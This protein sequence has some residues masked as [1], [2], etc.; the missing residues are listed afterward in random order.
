[1]LV[2]ALFLMGAGCQHQQ[3]QIIN[4]PPPGSV[5]TELTKVALPPYV[6]EAPDNLLIECFLPP[7]E[8]FGNPVAL[9]VQPISGQHP[10]RMDGTVGLGIYGSVPLVGLTLD[11]GAER[12]RQYV[13]SRLDPDLK[14][15][16]DKLYVIV[17]VLSY[18]TK[19][20]YVITDGAGFGEQVYAFPNTGNETVLKALANINGVPAVGSKRNIWVARRTPHGGCPDQI[21]PVDWIGIT[22]HGI[23]ATNYQLMPGDRVYVASDRI[24]RVD[25]NLS[26]ILSPIE[27]ILGVTLLGSST[28]NSIRINPNLGGNNNFNNRGF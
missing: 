16:P 26:K 1:V 15:T 5:P 23:S 20:Y 24:Q 3:Q 18:N 19:E 21:L 7:K 2:G 22:Q 4:V 14:I 28:V 9:P 25:R 10:V 8:A 6:I 11:Q 13:A 12:I 27:R 17:D